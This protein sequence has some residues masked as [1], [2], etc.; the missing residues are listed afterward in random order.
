MIDQPEHE[1]REGAKP[2]VPETYFLPASPGARHGSCKSARSPVADRL[3][4]LKASQ[5][6]TRSGNWGSRPGSCR[7]ALRL[8][9]TSAYRFFDLGFRLARRY[10]GR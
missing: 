9:S 1:V 10:S 4:R 6:V 2:Q 7:S 3:R 8:G 5:R